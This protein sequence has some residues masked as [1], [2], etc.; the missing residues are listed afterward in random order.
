MKHSFN[1]E[2]LTP[3]KSL[4]IIAEAINKSRWDFQKSAGNP[5]ILNGSVI[6]LVAGVILLMLQ[7]TGNPA[8]HFLW[9]AIA[10]ITFPLNYMLRQ[11]EEK[12]TG[13]G[14]DPI[15]ASIGAVWICFGILSVLYAALAFLCPL[16]SITTAIVLM[17]GLSAAITGGITKTWVISALG[18]IA[19][20][21]GTVVTQVSLFSM[22]A[23]III[24]TEALLVLVIPG[25]I[26]NYKTRK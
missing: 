7:L 14:E 8:W 24:A 25:L 17:M 20:L 1:N 5:M 16:P 10:L 22:S 19:G 9:F 12:K 26:Y 6:M 4:E 23:P 13:H 2:G 21:G 11:K 15:S 18:I 3:E